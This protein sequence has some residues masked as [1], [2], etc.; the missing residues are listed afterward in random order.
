MAIVLTPPKKP[1]GNIR[2]LPLITLKEGVIFP[3]TEAILTFG[4]PA[5]I[6]G[7][8][9]AVQNNSEVCFVSQKSSKI[10]EPKP[11]TLYAVGTICQV[12]KTLPVNDE[13]H[14]IVKGIS[15]VKIHSID[16]QGGKLLAAISLFP[17]V[18]ETSQEV[19]ALV[20]H[21]SSEI[22]EAV[23]LG[24]NN[25]EVPTFMKIISTASPVEISH[26]IAS[27]LNIKNSDKQHLL[28]ETNLKARL[29]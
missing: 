15:R 14:A 28:E 11:E 10:S 21:I 2:I 9:E 25:I 23:N 7:V 1:E 19:T 5:S 20:N 24:K 26:Q 17:D 22:K 27:V 18:V 8:N 16:L 3:D 4:R 13:L 29:I 6:N 12:V